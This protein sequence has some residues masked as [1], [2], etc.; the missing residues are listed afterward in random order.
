[1]LFNSTFFANLVSLKKHLLWLV[2][3]ERIVQFSPPFANTFS[4]GGHSKKRHCLTEN[5]NKKFAYCYL[6][7]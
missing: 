7:S 5:F 2:E 6:N 1:M 4:V 3:I